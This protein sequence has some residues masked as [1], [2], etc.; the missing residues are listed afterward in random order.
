M[1]VITWRSTVTAKANNLG[2]LQ[3]TERKSTMA[4]Y[5]A[6]VIGLGWMGLLYDMAGR[7]PYRQ[8]IDTADSIDKPTPELDVHRQFHL[9]ERHLP[10]GVP[11]SYS[12]ALHDR[13]EIDLVAGCD[14]DPNRL[15]AFGDRYG[16]VALYTDGAEMLEKEKLDIVAIAT[17]TR[18]RPELVRLAVENGAKAIVTD[19]PMCHTLAE[20]DLMVG[21][22]RDAGVPLNCGAISTTHPSFVTARELL[23]SG[24]IGDVTSMETSFRPGAQH[25]NWSYFLDSAPAWVVGT[26]DKPPLETGSS[27]FTGQGILVCKDG[28]ILHFREG[29]PMLR[30]SGTKGE[31][32]HSNQRQW[33]LSQDFETVG[34]IKRVD[35]PWPGP[36]TG[37]YG[38]TYS[39]ADVMD[40]L[41]GK[42]DEPKNSGRRVAVAL[43]AEIALKVSSA[44]GG[45]RVDLPL[46][47]RSLGLE[48]EWWR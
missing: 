32:V 15:K 22:C 41:E 27:E 14:R 43:E 47:D 1:R 16:D 21:V 37:H 23:D 24:A 7:L 46:E 8:G 26:A 13:P 29:A 42:L 10:K 45:Q 5:R 25:Q 48:Y 6:G 31:M 19:K 12:E 36:Q 33:T 3:Y 9:Y 44:N 17:N 40:C 11:T 34:G 18:S 30:I 28:T 2:T 4:K 39:V 20:A 38:T 35:V